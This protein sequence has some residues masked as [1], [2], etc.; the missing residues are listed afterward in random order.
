MIAGEGLPQRFEDTKKDHGKRSPCLIS[1]IPQKLRGV[2]RLTSQFN[3]RD[4]RTIRLGCVGNGKT[5]MKPREEI[6]IFLT[7]KQRKR[8]YVI[9]RRK[10][11]RPRSRGISWGTQGPKR[12]GREKYNLKSGGKFVELTDTGQHTLFRTRGNR[13]EIGWQPYARISRVP[14][15]AIRHSSTL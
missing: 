10:E 12:A 8:E 11:R 7:S 1:R 4:D 5:T 15:I 13:P 14:H 6:E 2:R 3:G 9:G